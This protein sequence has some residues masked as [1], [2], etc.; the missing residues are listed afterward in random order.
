MITND[1]I[2]A[3][4]SLLAKLMDIH[5]ENA[6]KA[7]SYAAAA[8]SIDKLLTPLGEMERN[9]IF[10]IKGIGESA[11]KRILE[12]LDTGQFA[13]LND[14]IL[15]TPPGILE[16]LNIK[17]IG[18]KKIATIWKELEIETLGELLYACNE[19]RLT[20][21]KG[22]GEK[23]QLNIKESIEFYMGSMGR[24]LYQQ[25]EEVQM[26]LEKLFSQTFPYR[27]ISTGEFRRQLEIIDSIEWVTNAKAEALSAFMN[28]IGFTID[29][30]QEDK[31]SYRNEKNIRV[32]FWLADEEKIPSILFKSSCSE[33]FLNVWT[34]KFGWN[35]TEIYDSEEK[36]FEKAGCQ[37]IP[38]YMREDA[39][40]LELA[41]QHKLSPAITE[42]EIKGIIHSHS[43][44]S[45]GGNTILQMAEAA[46]KEGLEYLVIS[47]HSKSAFYANGLSI[48]RVMQ[49]HQEIEKINQQ[50]AP[51][52][53][54]KSIE[55]DIL[56][57]GSLDYPDEVLEKFDLVIASVHS[58]LK[59]NE[60][61]ANT[62][63]I[64]A[65]E[66]RYTSILGHPTGRLLLSRA[67]YPIDHERI[68]DACAANGVVIELN[69]HPRR[70]D[71]DWRW[72]RKAL[73]KN[74]MISIN[75]DA[76]TIDG[77]KDCKYGVLVAQ[78]AGLMP[79]Q[80][81]SSFTLSELETFLLVQKQKR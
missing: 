66:N 20:L 15:K 4:F 32:Q 78:K 60:E 16:M 29:N 40:S 28:Q 76:H 39:E 63:V 43:T 3:Q 41:T 56:N 14:M 53:I 44:W 52:K 27:F 81:L 74:V 49:Q 42:K 5:G 51:F 17:G 9:A 30:Q 70:L 24:Y 61:K 64:K 62:R 55:S 11:G 68:I 12:I 1:E 35:E 25:V 65:I 73:Q 36:I 2:A 80:N 50:L 22:F 72:I 37:F 38:A 54:F 79:A 23:T 47:D 77:F 31:I 7:K 6:F 21:Y 33:L 48:E 19:N 18:P 57:D 67:G 13:T 59:M 75:P 8:F 71:L 10:S 58:N 46:I 34:K 45:D 69:A 26:E